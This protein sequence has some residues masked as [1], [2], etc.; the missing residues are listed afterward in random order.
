MYESFYGLKANPFR[1]APD[2]R[3]FYPSAGHKR[4]LAYLRYGLQQG[5]G[6]VAVTGVPGTGKTMLLQ[7]LLAELSAQTSVVATLSSTNLSADDV[8]RAAADAF[9]VRP[10]G[11]S[12]SE[13]LTA[14]ERFFT[15]TVQ[16]G[17]RVLLIVD[18]AQNLPVQSLE[19]LRMLS[20]FQLG[21]KALL[22]I[23]LLGQQQLRQILADP[24][25]EQLSQRI[26]AACHLQPISAEETRAYIE[27]RLRLAGW[28]GDPS[29]TGEALALIC[30]CS[31]GLPRLINV[32]CE[33]LFLSAYLDEK[34]LIDAG[35]VHAMIAELRYEAGAGW[36][37]TQLD[38]L[39]LAEEKLAPLP[40]PNAVSNEQ[41]PIRD[42]D[43][44]NLASESSV[45]SPAIEEVE[46]TGNVRNQPP[47]MDNTPEVDR[48]GRVY[49]P[50]P[51]T[52]PDVDNEPIPLRAED[53]ETEIKPREPA[54]VIVLPLRHNNAVA[55]NATANNDVPIA[56]PVQPAK[57]I[58]NHRAGKGLWWGLGS[59]LMVASIG[60]WWLM[61]SSM[62]GSLWSLIENKVRAVG[63]ETTI[64]GRIPIETPETV[65]MSS[66]SGASPAEATVVAELPAEPEAPAVTPVP[67][68]QVKKNEKRV[69]TNKSVMEEAAVQKR[70][71]RA[72]SAE[73]APK[74]SMARSLPAVNKPQASSATSKSSVA[75][76]KIEAQNG[77]AVKEANALV[78]P[79][80]VAK[81]ET[82]ED[83]LSAQSVAAAEVTKANP[84][85]DERLSRR[86]LALT[87]LLFTLEQ[88]YNNGELSSLVGLFAKDASADGSQ[89]NKRIARDYKELFDSTDMRRM[90]ISDVKWQ[91]VDGKLLGTGNFEAS[92]WRKSTE[93]PLVSSGRIQVSVVQEGNRF[94]IK[95]LVHQVH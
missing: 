67:E 25:M 44:H 17:K 21:N 23:I 33:R 12:K 9:G 29:I 66:E 80:P 53:A 75:D 52:I 32:F 88:S 31:K 38:A 64:D 74:V 49:T 65:T 59:T 24:D 73:L 69:E 6:F 7:T 35:A 13:L 84:Q 19:E 56:V 54:K 77:G 94:V 76:N 36:D 10:S 40:D 61:Q 87:E 58:A 42:S 81:I 63:N 22:Q 2:P 86:E 18:E 26:I 47:V 60:A 48:F 91:D 72:M 82:A 68:P 50:A 93:S 14:I 79:P 27:H 30:R 55:D 3:F 90:D 4:G 15:T 37:F 1:L 83:R 95:R 85:I 28:S 70:D 16:N 41:L 62:F 39:S 92:V 20:N 51:E 5:Q 71:V 57:V 89:G 78:A 11:T 34:H 8:L 46:D 45:M 43:H